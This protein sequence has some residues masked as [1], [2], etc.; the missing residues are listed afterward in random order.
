MTL[1]P[2][3]QLASA[4]SAMLDSIISK[5]GVPSIGAAFI[6]N[7]SVQIFVGG[8]RKVGSDAVVQTADKFHLGSCTKAMSATVAAALV[9]KGYF[10]WDDTLSTVL[11]WL[12]KKMHPS[13]KSVTVEMLTSQ[14][15]GV[16][17]DL[18]SFQNGALWRSL[19]DEKLNPI[20]GR[21]LTAEA[22]LST[23]PAYEAGTKFEYSNGN[24]MILG[25]I[26]ESVT[27]KSWET[28]MQEELFEPLSM[29]SC[30]YGP[31]ADPKQDPPD[32]PWPHQESTKG[33]K[34]VTPDFY[35]DNPPSL[36][37]AGTVHCS[38][39]DWSKFVSLHING[40]HQRPTKILNTESF[41]KLH[42]A[43]NGESYTYGGWVRV[44]ASWAGGFA[45]THGGSN[46][47]NFANAWIAPLKESAYISVTTLGGDNA[48]KA[49]DE[50]ITKM[51]SGDL[52]NP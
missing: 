36:G 21:R 7:G 47:M 37:P 18:V 8:V 12:A 45:L 2:A 33:A 29:T 16:T 39:E 52:R 23:A 15:S 32:Q 1:P 25:A 26:L 27:G 20:D 49:T 13:Y 19:W 6:K 43:P 34:P 9:E 38:M 41:E 35:A 30:G 3:T 28:L 10:N 22:V 40:F 46:T 17:E 11:P 44:N 42:N 14:R 24:Y 5:Y 31:Q 51:I 50:A 4:N 48:F